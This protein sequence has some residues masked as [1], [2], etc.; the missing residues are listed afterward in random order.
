MKRIKES[1]GYVL[2]QDTKTKEYRIEE[3]DPSGVDL[4][5]ENG[6]FKARLRMV[7]HGISSIK[8][9]GSRFADTYKAL[10]DFNKIVKE[11]EGIV[12]AHQESREL[13]KAVERHINSVVME[14]GAEYDVSYTSRRDSSDG[15]QLVCE[16]QTPPVNTF[17][18][19][20]G[21]ALIKLS[22]PSISKESSAINVSAIPTSVG[23][24]NEASAYE[25]HFKSAGRVMDDM[26]DLDEH[27]FYVEMDGFKGTRSY[28][29]EYDIQT[30]IEIFPVLEE[31]SVDGGRFSHEEVY[32][33]IIRETV[34]RSP[35]HPGFFPAAMKELERRPIRLRKR[36]V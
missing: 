7:A 10:D 24:R 34:L 19:T 31:R 9:I 3:S 27:E 29:D 21:R 11:D 12:T 15:L 5:F 36:I 2:Y 13:A 18:F 20:S 33:T 35:E 6:M 26:S 28:V 23:R 22:H 1:A 32:D 17:T 25:F 14:T 4:E 16:I 30:L 8:A